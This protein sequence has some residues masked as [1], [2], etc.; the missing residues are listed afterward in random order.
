[1]KNGWSIGF[2]L[3]LPNIACTCDADTRPGYYRMNVAGQASFSNAGSPGAFAIQRTSFA[4]SATGAVSLG[5]SRSGVADGLRSAQIN[6]GFSVRESYLVSNILSDKFEAGNADP[7]FMAIV[8]D[9]A[10]RALCPSIRMIASTVCQDKKTIASVKVASVWMSRNAKTIMA[11][12]RTDAEGCWYLAQYGE[13]IGIEGS[14]SS[15]F[16]V[17]A[18]FNPSVID[19]LRATDLLKDFSSISS[20]PILH[21]E[22]VTFGS[23][24]SAETLTVLNQ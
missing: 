13:E 18:E 10:N 24:T 6:A 19:P 22:D 5:S 16:V 17:E 15:R 9:V 7:H 21:L 3:L 4:G 11:S 14:T 1:M 12:A 2:M 23:A 8:F 20:T